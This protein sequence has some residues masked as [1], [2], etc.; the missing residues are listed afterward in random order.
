MTVPPRLGR[1][2]AGLA[3]GSLL[4]AEEAAAQGM[5]LQLPAPAVPFPPLP[6]PTIPNPALPEAAT[7]PFAVARSRATVGIM[8]GPLVGTFTRIADDIARFLVLRAPHLPRVIP[9]I[10]TGGPQVVQDILTIGGLDGAV[11][12]AVVMD[13]VRR[14]GWLP[15]VTERVASVAELYAEETHIVASTLIPNVAALNGRVVNVGVLGGGTDVIARRLFDGLGI[16]P[17]YDNRPTLEALRGVPSGNPAAVAFIAGKP[18]AAFGEMAIVGNLHFVPVT[19]DLRTRPRVEPLYRQTVLEH[20]D[21]PRFIPR[22]QTVP[23]VS[24]S[25]FLVTQAHPDGSERKGWVS[26]VVLELVQ[27]F[28]A[29]R[30]GAATSALHPKWR[31]VNVLTR[32]EGYPRSPEVTAWFNG[33]DAGSGAAR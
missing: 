18:V 21:Y 2:S 1:R 4:L 25:V 6:L 29:L 13:A 16:R 22:G 3:L 30:A 15:D 11:V 9:M 32:L 26:Q 12:S 24:S 8:G 14:G 5:P 20:A 17:I 27:N 23:T 10:G 7:P 28:V 33:P 31:E 19:L